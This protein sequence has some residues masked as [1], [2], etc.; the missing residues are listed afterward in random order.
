M[1]KE[2]LQV[3]QMIQQLE[4]TASTASGVQFLALPSVGIHFLH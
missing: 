1:L 2:D 3:V 4:T